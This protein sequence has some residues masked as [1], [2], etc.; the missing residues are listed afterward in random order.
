[1]EEGLVGACTLD[2]ISYEVYLTLI[3]GV[4]EA[5]ISRSH[6]GGT[7]SLHPPTSLT[8]LVD[9]KLS[10]RME[11]RNSTFT[12]AVC[13]VPGPGSQLDPVLVGASPSAS[14]LCFLCFGSCMQEPVLSE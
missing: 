1:M 6:H 10:R 5:W 2:Q 7:S 13:G 11:N 3:T 14:P 9:G 8:A 12:E 4:R